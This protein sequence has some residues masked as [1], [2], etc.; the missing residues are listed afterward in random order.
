MTKYYMQ[1]DEDNYT[2]NIELQAKTDGGARKL[3]RSIA[4]QEQIKW[5]DIV[6]R[7]IDGRLGR[8]CNDLKRWA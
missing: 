6:Y 3:A 7:C 5:Y 1:Y 8:L 2:C 4:K